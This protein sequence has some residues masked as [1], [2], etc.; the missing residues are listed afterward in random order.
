[1]S[2][3][4][5]LKDSGKR[6]EFSTGMVRDSGEKILRPDLLWVPGLVRLAELYGKG[7]V[8]YAERNWEKAET[9]I[10]RLR[11]RASA[12]RHFIQWFRGDRDEDHG[13]AV[14]FNIWGAEMV[15]GKLDAKN[16]VG[17]E[18][19]ASEV[20]LVLDGGCFDPSSVVGD[21]VHDRGC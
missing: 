12:F 19:G 9:E 7:A 17:R 6:M 14:I 10:E 21:P 5:S 20:P 3:N 11:F 8:K 2:D 15:K 1:M 18:V 4:F 16:S 13:S